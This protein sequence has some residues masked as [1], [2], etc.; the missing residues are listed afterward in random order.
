M[1]N[2]AA[3]SDHRHAVQR[4]GRAG[5]ADEAAEMR[6][7][8]HRNRIAAPAHQAQIGDHEGNAERH[9]HLR[10][11]LAGEPAQQEALHQRA[12]DRDLDRG[13]KR[14]HPEIQ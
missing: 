9:Q 2:T 3:I 8:R 14:G 5:D 11:L 1:A 12:K 7:R 10:Q 4:E 13:D 6:R